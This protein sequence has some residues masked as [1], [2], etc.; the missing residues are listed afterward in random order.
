MSQHKYQYAHANPVVNTDPS[1]YVTLGEQLSALSVKSVLASMSYV[2]GYG[3]GAGIREGSGSVTLA[4]YDQFLA[5]FADGISGGKSTQFRAQKYGNT[6]I[7]NHRGPF[8]NLGRR[9]GV[10]GTLAL[11]WGAPNALTKITWGQRVAQLYVALSTGSSAYNSTQNIHEGRATIW[12]WLVFLPLITAGGSVIWR[13]L[14]GRTPHIQSNVNIYDDAGNLRILD[15]E[16]L[17]SAAKQFKQFPPLRTQ[18]RTVAVGRIKNPDGTVSMIVSTSGNGS[19]GSRLREL[20]ERAAW[21][22]PGRGGNDFFH[23]ETRMI[24]WA[25]RKNKVIEAIGVSHQGGICLSCYT[26]LLLRGIYP[27]SKLNLKYPIDDYLN[28]LGQWFPT[29]L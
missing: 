5:G 23:A 1:G 26:D 19:I 9:M 4:I 18:A 11:G 3:I 29:N 15:I 7:R 10:V 24:E 25:Q 28:E 22:V 14:A 6:A 13:E 20:T 27:A 8:F 17:D 2:G 16:E 12:D 21:L